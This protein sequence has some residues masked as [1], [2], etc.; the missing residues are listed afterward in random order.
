ML[1][2]YLHLNPTFLL[3][4]YSLDK[5]QTMPRSDIGDGVS[6]VWCVG[7]R[8][9]VP[10]LCG[11][12]LNSYHSCSD[13][14]EIGHHRFFAPWIWDGKKCPIQTTGKWPIP[15]RHLKTASGF[16]GFSG[17]FVNSHLWL[18]RLFFRSRMPNRWTVDWNTCWSLGSKT[19]D[20]LRYK[21]TEDDWYYDD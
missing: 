6:S 18:S 16:K 15:V 9:K 12:L 3:T 7:G 5:E 2:T 13:M 17:S 8:T 11:N 4:S 19:S 10:H 21:Y 20:Y 14:G 1:N